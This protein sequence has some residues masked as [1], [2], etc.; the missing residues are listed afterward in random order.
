MNAHFAK[1]YRVRALLLGAL[2]LAVL[3]ARPGLLPAQTDACALV[4]AG[5]AAALLG[6][7]P[8]S[9]ATPGGRACT[10]TG[11]I[12]GHKLLILTYKNTGVPGEAAYMGAHQGAQAADN[13]KV[14]DEAGL[15]DKA[16]SSTTSF[17]AVFVVLKQGRLLQLQYWTGGPGTIQDV[18]ALRP[19]VQKAVAAF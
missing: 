9:K 14:S 6:G 10:W 18:A 5:D 7:T 4:K 2:I 15:G 1:A 8:A 13:A 16:F 17:G 12:A 19:V 11:A 3:L